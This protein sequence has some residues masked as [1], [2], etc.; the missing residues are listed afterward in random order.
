MTRSKL[1]R[2]DFDSASLQGSR[3]HSE[4]GGAEKP[5]TRSRRGSVGLATWS[6]FGSLYKDFDSASLRNYELTRPNSVIGGAETTGTLSCRDTGGLVTRS[7][8][9]RAVSLCGD[10]DS[11]SLPDSRP[12][13]VIGGAETAGTQ[14]SRCARGRRQN[15]SEFDRDAVSYDLRDSRRHSVTGGADTTSPRPVTHSRFG[16]YAESRCGDLDSDSLRDPEHRS[17][18]DG[19]ERPRS[20]Q[21]KGRV[22]AKPELDR[23]SLSLADEDPSLLMYS[24]VADIS[25]R[26]GAGQSKSFRALN[27]KLA[28]TKARHNLPRK[29]RQKRD[30]AN[31]IE[32]CISDMRQDRAV[33]RI[34]SRRGS[35]GF[36]STDPYSKAD[37]WSGR[38]D[39]SEDDVSILLSQ[40]SGSWGSGPDD[41]SPYRRLNNGNG[42]DDS[43]PVL[44]FLRSDMGGGSVAMP[45]RRRYSGYNDNDDQDRRPKSQNHVLQYR[46][47]VVPRGR[48]YDFSGRR[49]YESV[50]FDGP[51]VGLAGYLRSQT[52]SVAGRRDSAMS[53]ERY[54]PRT[55]RPGRISNLRQPRQD[56]GR[57]TMT[58][59]N[60]GMVAQQISPQTQ[61]SEDR[62]NFDFET[63][64]FL[65]KTPNR[66][67]EGE[68]ERGFGRG[69][70]AQSL[71]GE[72]DN[73]Q[74]RMRKDHSSVQG[75]NRG[76]SRYSLEENTS[77]RR[78]QR[79]RSHSVGVPGSVQQR[80]DLAR[81]RSVD[82]EEPIEN[83]MNKY[84]FKV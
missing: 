24:S 12:R 65:R 7:Q 77:D 10:F 38:D 71:S 20:R 9:G 15:R 78:G 8:F 19:A 76:R 25:R 58:G 21:N 1:D 69:V 82:R 33:E 11:A 63:G 47:G 66:G 2:G 18:F 68:F 83:V 39:M 52:G 72:S 62:H 41:L 74:A 60:Y 17:V 26:L 75:S 70:D 44:A 84:L 59:R 14:A 35:S 40:S 80:R 64:Y 43:D 37:N 42:V 50:N 32:N 22:T 49:E 54:D 5:G 13:S 27:E 30:V 16:L 61:D 29:E 48:D 56:R 79:L 67:D 28:L 53:E 23:A 36:L 34:A 51:D 45:V 73:N 4:I 81:P 31:K 6:K 57:E 55:G 3:P 46:D